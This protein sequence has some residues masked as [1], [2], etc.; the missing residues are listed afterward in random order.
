MLLTITTTHRP[1]TDLG[2]L[3]HKRPGRLH[4]VDLAF[5][6]G[7][8]FYP[9]AA[10]E[11]CTFSLVLDIDPVALV[12]GRGSGEGLLDQYVND[13]PYAASSHLSVAIAQGLRSALNGRSGERQALADTAIPLVATVE[14]CPVRGQAD[15]VACL[16]APLGY[17]VDV[18]AIGADPLPPGAAPA[19]E[20]QDGGRPSARATALDATAR[21]APYVA[22][23]LS[24]TTRL[25]DLLAHLYVLIPVL[26]RR[27]H[28]YVERGEVEKLLAKGEGWLA[29]HPMRDLIVQRYLHHRRALTNEL[30]RRLVEEAGAEDETD[31]ATPVE[32][33]AVASQAGSPAGQPAAV[34][35]PGGAE[36]DA[37]PAA[38]PAEPPKDAAETAIERPIRLHETRLDAVAAVLRDAGCRRVVDLGCGSGKLLKRL[39]AERQFTELL[40]VDV[41]LRDL[42]TAARRLR[43]DRVSE[44]QRKRITLLQGALTYRDRRIEG[45]DAAALVEVIEHLEPDRLPALERVVFE[46]ARPGLVVVT[47]PNVEYNVR[48]S[49]LAPGQLRH[50]DHRFEW[51]RSEFRAWAGA[52][53]GR[54][55]YGLDI[56]PLRPEDPEVGPPS[57][58]GVFTR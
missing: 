5:G 56:R 24:G 32:V 33:D 21:S 28:Y 16:F 37:L 3:L 18:R 29:S 13:R 34:P 2:Y 47:T 39:L 15:L 41:S 12:R 44:R 38:E 42:E 8:M 17:A 1:A 40:G 6:K 55:G 22:L 31:A 26:D 46:I 35:G 4:T 7:L 30:V 25:R 58:M 52:V 45:F 54:C 51:T 10:E 57:Q 14:P 36:E 48:F 19:P 11:R 50:A 43:L 23:T 9:E 27:K 49:G 53:A 20:G